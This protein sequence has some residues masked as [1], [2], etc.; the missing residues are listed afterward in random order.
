MTDT[1][2]TH[3]SEK[4]VRLQQILR[5][6]R[7]VMV[8]YSGGIDS[9]LVYKIAYDTLGD[10][11]LAVTAISPTFPDVEL[12]TARKVAGEIGGRHLIIK[13][14]Q[15]KISEFVR[16]DALRCFHCK[17][18]LYQ[19][20]SKIQDNHG[21]A[22]I[23]DGT[24]L[25]DMGDDRPGITAARE[26][27]VRSP[28]VEAQCSKD[29]VRLLAKAL[30]VSTWDKPAAAC[31]SSRIP[32]DITITREKLNRVERAES[33]LFEEGFQQVR[34]RDHG[35]T[36]RVEVGADEL[37]GILDPVRRARVVAGIKEAGF[38]FVALDLEGYRTGSTNQTLRG[39]RET[40]DE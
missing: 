23:I 24:N 12:Q 13:T 7:S 16:N 21:S 30:G 25:D 4:L 36:A 26:W 2:A 19:A 22:V 15:L 1:L 28:L 40:G 6:M 8:A 17:T 3:L 14:D 27:G 35:D 5:E 9:T 31:L 11:A 10:G 37:A 33:V 32:R 39:K 18:D 38:R 34:V 29:D 20:L